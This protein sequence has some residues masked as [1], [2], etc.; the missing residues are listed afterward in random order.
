MS[1]KKK[2]FWVVDGATVVYATD[3][4]GMAVAHA[5]ARAEKTARTHMVFEAIAAHVCMPFT[6][7]AKSDRRRTNNG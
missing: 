1:E 7:E 4:V 6:K 2:V 5:D 3:D